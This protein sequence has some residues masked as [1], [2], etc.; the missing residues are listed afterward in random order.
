MVEEIKYARVDSDASEDGEGGYQRPL[1]RRRQHRGW[2]SALGSFLV[3]LATMGAATALYSALTMPAQHS[4]AR[5]LPHARNGTDPDTGL[6]LSWSHGDCGNS[7][8]DARARGCL[9]SIVLHSW[10]PAS[11]LT[12]DDAQD[13]RDMYR[14]RQWPYETAAGRN[15]TMLELGAGDYGHFTTTFDWHVAHCMYVWKRLH[16]IL[17]DPT[18]ELDSYT[19]NYHHTSHCVKMIGGHPEGMKDSGTKIFVKYPKC[20]K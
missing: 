18:Q 13:A 5:N 7:P 10:L 8:E 20:A 6:P 14:G 1:R 17:L 15:L 12:D 19:A 4:H 2:V 11:C 9:Y 3:G 16:R